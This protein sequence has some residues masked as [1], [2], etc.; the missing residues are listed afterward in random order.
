MYESAIVHE[1]DE[2]PTFQTD[3][4]SLHQ[5]SEHATPINNTSFSHDF[6]KSNTTSSSHPSQRRVDPSNSPFTRYIQKAPPPPDNVFNTHKTIDTLRRQQRQQQRR[7]RKKELKERNKHNREQR[8]DVRPDFTNQNCIQY[9]P[10]SIQ[11]F[12]RD[13]DNQTAPIVPKHQ[14]NNVQQPS[15]VPYDVITTVPMQQAQCPQC[16]QQYVIRETTNQCFE[17]Q[18][19]FIEQ[20]KYETKKTLRQIQDCNKII[21]I[22]QP[23]KSFRQEKQAPTT[24]TRSKSIHCHEYIS[25]LFHEE[26]VTVVDD[27]HANLINKS[28]QRPRFNMIQRRSRSSSGVN[29]VV[30]KNWPDHRQNSYE[31]VIAALDEENLIIN[32]VDFYPEN[33]RYP[34]ASMPLHSRLSTSNEALTRPNSRPDGYDTVKSCS[35]CTDQYYLTRSLHRRHVSG[36]GSK[37]RGKGASNANKVIVCQS[38]IRF[39][40]LFI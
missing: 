21:K 6:S 35:E 15:Y 10:S 5:Q 14:G 22:D 39:L 18:N 24:R 11:Q 27:C 30:V 4:E 19:Q 36:H 1:T 7:E 13:D 23:Q 26:I 25:P 28:D 31:T 34:T 17:N 16:P 29:N 9:A 8:G 38:I 3:F 33:E 12:N 2:S 20:P 40:L 37:K 32:N